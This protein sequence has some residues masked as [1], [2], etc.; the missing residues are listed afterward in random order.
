MW[1]SSFFQAMRRVTGD[2][3][4]RHLIG[5]Y[6]DYVIEVAMDDGAVLVDIDTPEDA[7]SIV[8]AGGPAARE[9]RER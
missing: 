8:M 7:S 3:G 5:E 4:A 9:T 1:D 2:S 6:G